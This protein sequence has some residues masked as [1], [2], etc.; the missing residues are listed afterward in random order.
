MIY[1]VEGR[2]ALADEKWVRG[3]YRATHRDRA[4]AWRVTVQQA[5]DQHCRWKMETRVVEIE[6][7]IFDRQDAI[8]NANNVSNANG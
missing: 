3:D 6:G 8:R 5:F 2:I 4:E 1:A 7:S